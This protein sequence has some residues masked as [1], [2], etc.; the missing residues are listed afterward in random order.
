[1]NSI[2]Q[3]MYTNYLLK[4]L[5]KKRQTAGSH[6]I[7]GHHRGQTHKPSRFLQSPTRFYPESGT[8]FKIKKA[9]KPKALKL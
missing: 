8:G 1:M 7:S 4:N 3:T 6:V 2:L 5:T 9:P